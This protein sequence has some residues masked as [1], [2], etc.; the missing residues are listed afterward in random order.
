MSGK[1]MDLATGAEGAAAETVLPRREVLASLGLGAA[2]LLGGEAMGQQSARSRNRPATRPGTGTQMQ[3]M[4]DDETGWDA[5]TGRYVL[6]P[7]PYDY[8]ALEP[9][10]DATTMRIHHDIHHAGYV[11]GLNATL[12]ALAEIRNGSRGPDEIKRWSRQ[13]AFD[14]S[15]HFLHTLFWH[16]M[17]PDGGGQPGGAIGR[18]IER[19]FGSFEQ[20]SAQFQDAAASVEGS[21]WGLLVYEPIAG[22][23]LVMQA[24]KHQNLTAWGVVPLVVIDVWEHAYYLKYQNRRK[25]YVGAFM[26]IINWEFTD[27]KLTRTMQAPRGAH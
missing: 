8:S 3:P 6:P 16:C 1:P 27:A 14:G 7:L 10:I 5:E 26:N 25:D 24:E 13:L 21:G 9:Y 12:D 20:F 2:A 19:D 22:K 18:Q 11:R 4:S 15:G 23:L 17:S